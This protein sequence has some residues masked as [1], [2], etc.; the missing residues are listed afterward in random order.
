MRFA[1]AGGDKMRIMKY[2][3]IFWDWN[4]TLLDDV[5]IA[6]DAMDEL[7]REY[8]LP[9]LGG[10]ERYKKVFCFPVSEYYRRLGFDFKKTPFEITGMEFIEKYDKRESRAMLAN[11]ARETLE[12]FRKVGLSQSVLSA[13]ELNAL[14]KQ[15]NLRGVGEYFDAILGINDRL[16]GGKSQLARQYCEEHKIDPARTV[17]IGDTAHD[18]DV[19]REIGCDC[20][21]VANGHE[22]KSSLLQ[23]TNR[24]ADSLS[25]AAEWVL[26][27]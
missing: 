16:A 8:S 19:A 10:E 17:L 15:I 24:V 2:E 20:I 12:Q 21:L 27:T 5:E 3:R 26:C 18:Y 25:Q 7:L 9:P 23:L 6:I 4:G 14:K 1:K 11:G 13:S 22:D